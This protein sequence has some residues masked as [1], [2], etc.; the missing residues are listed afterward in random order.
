MFALWNNKAISFTALII[1][2]TSFI[3]VE[4]R[5]LLW[6]N[7]K[8]T[9]LST[10]SPFWCRYRC[11]IVMYWS[12]AASTSPLNRIWNHVS[13]SSVLSVVF[14][15]AYLFFRTKSGWFVVKTRRGTRRL[16]RKRVVNAA[17]DGGVEKSP[18]HHS[19]I[20]IILNNLHDHIMTPWPRDISFHVSIA[21]ILQSILW[22]ILD[23]LQWWW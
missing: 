20:K 9:L 15:V 2:I 12:R 11:R 7:I 21:S 19:L 16:E 1:S 10:C 4:V 3:W 6:L 8:H 13:L 18:S 17:G 14:N 23:F 22:T 5:L